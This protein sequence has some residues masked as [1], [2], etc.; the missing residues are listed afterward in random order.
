MN[1]YIDLRVDLNPCTSDMTDLMASF[2]ADAGYE[3]FVADEKGLDAFIKSDSFDA[4]AME[5]IAADFPF[6]TAVT[7]SSSL[8]EGKDWNEEWEKNYFKPIVVGGRCVVHS[9]FHTDIPETEFDIVVDP[10]MAFGTGHHATTSQMLGFILDTDM[11]GKTVIDMGTG[12]GILAILC[13]MKG[14]SKA[15]GIDIETDATDNARQNAVLNKVTADFI[16]GNADSLSGL[17]NAD[18]F[19]ANINRNV[20]LN[21]ISAY[22]SRINR[23]GKLFLSGFYTADIPMIEEAASKCGLKIVKT[24]EENGWAAVELTKE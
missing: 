18:I 11:N 23:G 7:F 5:G 24:T 19:L 21:D 3:S 13:K 9:S 4:A 2:L 20:I 15:T 6:D 1:D 8:V 16:T 12:T 14:A 17:E 22:S 10:R